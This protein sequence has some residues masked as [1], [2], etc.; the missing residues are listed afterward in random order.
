MSGSVKQMAGYYSDRRPNFY[1]VGDYDEV[2][3]Q[4]QHMIMH[5]ATDATSAYL[6]RGSDNV[7]VLGTNPGNPYRS[8]ATLTTSLMSGGLQS[9]DLDL[10]LETTS[11]TYAADVNVYGGSS[12][13]EGLS[14]EE[15]A[16]VA[17]AAVAVVSVAGAGAFVY[18]RRRGIT[19][20]SI[21]EKLMP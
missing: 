21:K 4:F 1:A 3:H 13:E 6:R 12:S 14:A 17:I 10:V 16:G 18:A 20:A 7:V 19:L 2:T 15:T 5:S 11:A 8:T 9:E